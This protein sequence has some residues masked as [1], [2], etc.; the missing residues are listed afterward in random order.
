[1]ETSS[2]TDPVVNKSSRRLSALR[3]LKGLWKK[4]SHHK[5]NDQ[6][7]ALVSKN[8]TLGLCDL[9][10]VVAFIMEST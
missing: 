10:S 4:T 6:Q 1:M 8:T 7:P 2:A 3:S 9:H 5:H